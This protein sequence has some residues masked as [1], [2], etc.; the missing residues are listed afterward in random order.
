MITNSSNQVLVPSVAFP[1]HIREEIK[2]LAGYQANRKY[3]CGDTP[4]TLG[5]DA[6]SGGHMLL[7]KTCIQRLKK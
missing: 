7:Q 5:T 4:R 3:I 2:L 1:E 6:I